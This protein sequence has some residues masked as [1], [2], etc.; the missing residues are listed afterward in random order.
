MERAV[1]TPQIHSVDSYPSRINRTTVEHESM[2]GKRQFSMLWC[3]N[4]TIYLQIVVIAQ[5]DR[6]FGGNSCFAR[7]SEQ[8]GRLAFHRTT[9]QRQG[10]CGHGERTAAMST[11]G[12]RIVVAGCSFCWSNGSRHACPVSG[13][14]TAGIIVR[15]MTFDK[16]LIILWKKDRTLSNSRF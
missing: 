14:M 10:P 15:R 4:S 2:L 9:G 3:D 7:I 8:L 6:R 16:F 1:S 5:N 13:V 12:L 11:T